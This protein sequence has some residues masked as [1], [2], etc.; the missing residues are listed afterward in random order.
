MRY[1][2]KKYLFVG[3]EGDRNVFFQKA[4]ELGIVHFV[5]AKPTKVGHLPEEIQ[6]V[7]RAIKILQGLLPAEQDE[8]D[9]YD[10]LDHLTQKIV[11]LKHRE[12]KLSE[13]KRLIELEIIRVQMFGDFSPE[14][15][16]HVE[17]ETK[18][19]IQYFCA[20]KGS[21]DIDS[22][23]EGM[24][25]IGSDNLLE[26]F[27]VLNKEP[28]HYPRMIEVHIE[29]PLGALLKR[30][31]AIQ[32]SLQS[33]GHQLKPYARYNDFLHRGLI[34]KLN[35]YHLYDAKNNIAHEM[36]GSLFVVEGWVPKNKVKNV[37]PLVR[38]MNVH[39][40]EI[41][42]EPKD[43]IPTYLENHG[44]ARLGEDLIKIYDTPSY[45]DKDPSLWVLVFFSFFFAFIIGDAG[46]GLLF[47]AAALYV[48][49]KYT[50]NRTWSRVLKL[51]T[52]L[53][54]A[55]IVWGILTTSFFG[56]P[57]DMD[58]P[59]RKVSLI[60]WLVEKKTAYIITHHDEDWKEWVGKFPQLK[61]VTDPKTFLK[62]G[63]AK[64][65]GKEDY[66]IY[67]TFSDNIMFELAIFIGVVHII[68]SMLR[69]IRRHWS[70]YGWIL[71]IIGCYLYLPA[72]LN[73]TSLIHFVFG[74][75]RETAP[76]GGLYLI[77]G[78]VC[79]ATALSTVQHKFSGLLEP[80][81]V[82]QLFADS[83]SYLRLYALGLSGAILADTINDLAGEM[84]FVFGALIVVAGHVVNM[85]LSIMGG[86]IHGLRLNFLE[87]YHYSFEGG[88]KPF[89]PL[90]KLEIE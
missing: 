62:E 26:Y 47:L 88:G 49:Y 15:I 54:V 18:R 82:G 57:I 3:F 58:N 55:I 83:M 42:I 24:I 29:R 51:L 32:E 43:S 71:F 81:T 2:V 48:R 10:Q 17:K 31:Q 73:A 68:L 11:A 30:K 39:V 56:I 84:N 89:N 35:E 14:D 4:Q 16:S 38:E 1:D 19:K 85:I 87:W 78:G 59:L 12:E 75:N 6:N 46:Y 61:N 65:H 79:I 36:D 64:I 74:V 7:T 69:Y 45:T 13:E 21:A 20:K 28:Q 23:P 34:H 72:Y 80:M 90:R 53:S 52:L 5:P 70:Y 67:D 22:L 9:E 76:Q 37:L 60:Q 25:F 63:V 27:V 41:A 40:E 8:L 66:V 33:N 50:L 86:T 77:V 44:A